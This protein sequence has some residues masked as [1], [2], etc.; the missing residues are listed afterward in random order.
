MIYE[1]VADISVL[2]ACGLVC[3]AKENTACQ[4][5]VHSG[6][7]CYLGAFDTTETA[8]S[9]TGTYDVYINYRNF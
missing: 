2:N 3:Y 4:F 5:F 6:T 9:L 8:T 7:T 1:E